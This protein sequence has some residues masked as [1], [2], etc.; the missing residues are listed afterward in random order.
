MDA[1]ARALPEER[2]AVFRP[3]P[4]RLRRGEA[5]IHHSHVVHGSWANGSDRPRRAAVLNYMAPDTRSKGAEPLLRGVPPIAPGR[6]IDG[7]WFPI[8]L[9]LSLLPS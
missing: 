1:F 7:D 8:V 6:V 2:R 3:V 4:A 5:V 9:D